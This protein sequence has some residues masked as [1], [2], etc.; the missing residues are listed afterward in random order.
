MTHTLELRLPGQANRTI[1]IE[2]ATV[3]LCDDGDVATRWLRA[4][5]TAGMQVLDPAAAPRSTVSELVARQA[6]VAV[7]PHVLRTLG[8]PDEL[9]S[10]R[11][12][13][14][15]PVRRIMAWSVVALASTQRLLA[16][17]I[18]RLV[19]SPFERA[20]LLAHLRRI[21][22]RFDV[23]IAV[24][25]SDPALVSSAGSHLLVVSG[26]EVVESGPAREVVMAPTSEA[27]LERLRAT[28]IAHPLAMQVRRLQG[29]PQALPFAAT[30]VELPDEDSIAMAGGEETA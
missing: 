11:F 4:L 5:A 20:H 21:S 23:L 16:V 8:L 30:L 28:P 29:A 19:A 25:I 22:E 27:L 12:P 6:D 26:D 13:D 9:V 15:D 3:L 17:E 1:D 10:W 2:P 7:L 24:I 14:L 18:T